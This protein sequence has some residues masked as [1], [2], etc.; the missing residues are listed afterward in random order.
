MND[1]E[2]THTIYKQHFTVTIYSLYRMN[3][4]I[5][6]VYTIRIAYIDAQPISN[7]F[8]VFRKKKKT[9]N[10]IQQQAQPTTKIA[11]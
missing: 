2:D 3:P 1:Q 5:S 8:C 4:C 11:Q 6:C 10:K 7:G 9:Q